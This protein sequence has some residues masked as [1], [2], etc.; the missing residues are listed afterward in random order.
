MNCSRVM[1]PFWQ[2][3]PVVT[4]VKLTFTKYTFFGTTIT[5]LTFILRSRS[6]KFYPPYNWDYRSILAPEPL[7]ICISSQRSVLSQTYMI[8]DP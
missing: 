1:L 6:W 2:S 5:L 8:P 4:E 7:D 3:F